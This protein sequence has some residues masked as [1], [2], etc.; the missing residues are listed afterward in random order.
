MSHMLHSCNHNSNS[1]FSVFNYHDEDN[2]LSF[3]KLK[4]GSDAADVRWM[5]INSNL[6]LYASHKDFLKKTAELHNA[7]W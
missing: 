5:E 2:I 7:H 1:C 3:L 4:A 6:N